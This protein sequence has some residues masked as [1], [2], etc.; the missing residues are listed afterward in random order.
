[1]TSI[2][3]RC[4]SALRVITIQVPIWQEHIVEEVDATGRLALVRQR[5]IVAYQSM[6]DTCEC[7][8]CTGGY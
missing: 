8:R 1:M 4:G 2:C 6:D 3:D 7:P 5:R